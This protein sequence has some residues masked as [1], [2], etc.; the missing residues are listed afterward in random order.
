MGAAGV[1]LC[2]VLLC[3]GQVEAVTLGEGVPCSLCLVS[4]VSAGPPPPGDLPAPA[5][6]ADITSSDTRPLAAAVGYRVWGWPVTSRGDQVWLRLEPD[7]VALVVPVLLAERVTA[8]LTQRRC[9]PLVLVHPDAPEHRVL[10]AGEPYGVGLPWPTGVHRVGGT[11]SLPPTKTARGPVTWVYPPE[12]DALRLCREV[13]VF[14]A[15]RTALRG[16]PR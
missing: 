16:P 14:G 12:A 8:I 1:A 13:D 2:G 3:V 15:L 11:V 4:Q 5:P 6:P 7:A 9:P 10:L